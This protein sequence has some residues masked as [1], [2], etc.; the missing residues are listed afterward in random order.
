[1]SF[2]LP[3]RRVEPVATLVPAQMTIAMK[4]VFLFLCIPTFCI[5]SIALVVTYYSP[6]HHG[7][8]NVDYVSV[9]SSDFILL[10][11]YQAK[12]EQDILEVLCFFLLPNECQHCILERKLSNPF[13]SQEGTVAL[14][15]CQNAC[16]YCLDDLT[17]QLPRNVV[18]NMQHALV[19]LFIGPESTGHLTLD[20]FL[21][22]D[23]L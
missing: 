2:N 19:E 7:G 17:R 5:G 15:P 4:Y 8:C 9:S 10:N 22:M 23:A 20:D 11:A 18:Q 16:S 6:F 21:V 3:R 14:P 13:L 12:Q 1:M